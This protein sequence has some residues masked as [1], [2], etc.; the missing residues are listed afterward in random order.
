MAL[1]TMGFKQQYFGFGTVNCL[2]KGPPILWT[3]ISYEHTDMFERLI[4]RLYNEST[5]CRFITR[6]KDI[7]ISSEVLQINSIDFYEDE[8][9]VGEFVYTLP[10]AYYTSLTTGT[11]IRES[12]DVASPDWVRIGLS[13]LRC[14]C[15]KNR[16]LHST[17]LRPLMQARNPELME[18]FN[19]GTLTWE[20]ID[21]SGATMYH[22]NE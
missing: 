5:T 2:I 9:N 21:G 17:S 22:Q 8:Q 4:D 13:Y 12:F 18:Q 15:D 10:G 16:Q 1:A 11:S 19:L 6:H 14:K 20:D 7:V 3:G